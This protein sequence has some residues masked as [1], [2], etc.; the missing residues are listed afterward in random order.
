[1]EQIQKLQ[2]QLTELVQIRQKQELQRQELL[3]VQDGFNGLQDTDKI[4]V[5][6][7]PG[8]VLQERAE[9]T[10]T[11]QDRLKY[12]NTSIEKVDAD[13]KALQKKLMDARQSMAVAK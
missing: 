7:G 8:L 4:Y 10:S 1:M 2:Q 12:I 5:K 6:I 3:I 9:A 11:V 13:T